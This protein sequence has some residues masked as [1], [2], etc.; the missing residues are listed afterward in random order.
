MCGIAGLIDLSGD[1]VSPVILQRMTDAIAHRGPDGEGHWIEG[2]VGFGH[3][4]LAIIDLSPGGH[5][6][7]ISADG[8]YVITYNG[9]IYNFRELRAELQAAGYWFRSQSD[10]EVLLHALAY[11]GTEA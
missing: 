1:A 5:Q 8:R 10:T 6:P 7:M 4:R 11:W 2:P 9:E 3:R